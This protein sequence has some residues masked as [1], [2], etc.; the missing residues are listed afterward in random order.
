MQK[1]HFVY[2][3]KYSGKCD[4]EI[5]QKIRNTYLLKSFTL[6]SHSLDYRFV[7]HPVDMLNGSLYF[8]KLLKYKN[9]IDLT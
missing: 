5:D 8:L 1:F 9:A 4:M 3:Y 6:L 2:K 7:I